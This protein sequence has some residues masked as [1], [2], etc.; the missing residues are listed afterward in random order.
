[1]CRK[2]LGLF[3][4][5]FGGCLIDGM[6]TERSPR[7]KFHLFRAAFTPRHIDNQLWCIAGTTVPHTRQSGGGKKSGPQEPGDHVLGRSRGGFSTK[8]HLLCDGNGL[9]L[10]F[11]LTSGQTASRP[12]LEQL[13]VAADES[14][15]DEDGERVGLALGDGRR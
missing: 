8:I 14:L 3:G 12:S 11:H 5:Q 6:Q 15:F 13:L 2:N 9:P 10:H 1:M 4:K 7:A